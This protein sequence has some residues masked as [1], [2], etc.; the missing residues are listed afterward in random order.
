MN[1]ET[2]I[3]KFPLE[4]FKMNKTIFNSIILII[5]GI[6]LLFGQ[7]EKRFQFSNWKSQQGKEYEDKS[8]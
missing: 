3:H 8:H 4:T 6:S 5:M 7:D 1:L 2:K